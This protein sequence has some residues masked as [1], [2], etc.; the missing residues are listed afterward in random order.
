MKSQFIILKKSRRA[1]NGNVILLCVVATAVLLTLT[2]VIAS[3]V[4]GRSYFTKRI[5]DFNDYVL[6]LEDSNIQYRKE[7]AVLEAETLELV[8]Y[9]FQNQFYSR[10]QVSAFAGPNSHHNKYLKNCIASPF[11]KMIKEFY[12]QEYKSV[13]DPVTGAVNGDELNDIMSELANFLYVYIMSYRMSAV[14]PKVPYAYGLEKKMKDLTDD[15]TAA[16][17]TKGVFAMSNSIKVKKSLITYNGTFD[18]I[19]GNTLTGYLGY[20]QSG[21]FASAELKTELSIN[22]NFGFELSKV[23]QV[24][25]FELIP[26]M[27]DAEY[28]GA[29][30]SLKRSSTDEKLIV[31]T[32]TKEGER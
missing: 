5:A 17:D 4:I 7:F 9:Y 28:N 32:W 23:K 14:S 3:Q 12:D 21:V 16:L 19:D 24:V 25:A 1:Q 18:A 6:L 30:Y 15:L 31:T 11:Q 29:T 27:F 10:N 20:D 22:G 8:E 2:N 26:E 13:K